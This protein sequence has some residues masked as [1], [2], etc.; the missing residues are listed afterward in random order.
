M[1]PE[2]AAYKSEATKVGRN[3]RL[4]AVSCFLAACA[5]ILLPYVTGRGAQNAGLGYVF[6]AAG[7]TCAA[8][9]IY[10]RSQWVKTHPYTGPR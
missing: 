4:S 2:F 9:A 7:V 5:I 3:L 8:V 1:T 10:V 6:L